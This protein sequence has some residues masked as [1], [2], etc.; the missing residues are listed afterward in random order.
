[1]SFGGI[2]EFRNGNVKFFWE[3]ISISV[4]VVDTEVCRVVLFRESVVIILYKI[5]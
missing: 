5:F 3:C 1:M 2:I 4:Y